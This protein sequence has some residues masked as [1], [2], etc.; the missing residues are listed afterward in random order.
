MNSLGEHIRGGEIH[1]SCEPRRT[2]STRAATK[3]SHCSRVA[4]LPSIGAR[5]MQSARLVR[6]YS[7]W[8][9]L[10]FRRIETN[11]YNFTECCNLSGHASLH[12][13]EHIQH[14]TSGVHHDNFNY[15]CLDSLFLVGIT[16]SYS[17]FQ[18][19]MSE[20][21]ICYFAELTLRCFLHRIGDN[22]FTASDASA[23]FGRTTF[24]TRVDVQCSG[25]ISSS[26]ISIFRI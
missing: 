16:Y 12:T 9:W 21:G 17:H 26:A 20:F 7:I 19:T 22:T 24:K 13:H 10:L 23:C 18:E 4:C 5:C 3:N 11:K 14:T 2:R 6:D 1:E 15:S 8:L 25:N